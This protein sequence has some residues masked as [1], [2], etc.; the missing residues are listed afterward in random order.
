[1]AAERLRIFLKAKAK[2][3]AHEKRKLQNAQNKFLQLLQSDKL[4]RQAKYTFSVFVRQLQKVRTETYTKVF[5]EEQRKAEEDHTKVI[6]FTV[7]FERGSYFSL[8][9]CTLRDALFDYLLF[10]VTVFSQ[11][12]E[13]EVQLI[14]TRNIETVLGDEEVWLVLQVC[15]KLVTH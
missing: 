5:E 8:I 2:V 3:S 7:Y 4:T 13:R 11:E 9:S 6:L 15:N 12:R 10:R 1:M 14:A